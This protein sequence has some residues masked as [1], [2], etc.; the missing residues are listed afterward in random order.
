M[1]VYVFIDIEGR[2]NVEGVAK[3]K[4]PRDSCITFED[5]EEVRGTDYGVSVY[6]GHN[7][8]PIAIEVGL[9]NPQPIVRIRF[10]ERFGEMVN[11]RT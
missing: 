9:H 11:K 8:V 1:V 6:H 7:P 3:V 10:I 4:V 5:R 2:K